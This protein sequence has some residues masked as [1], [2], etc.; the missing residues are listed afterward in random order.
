ML[1]LKD[2]AHLALSIFAQFAAVI[3]HN[4]QSTSIEIYG[5]NHSWIFK[6]QR[7][8]ISGGLFKKQ[9]QHV[10]KLKGWKFS[11]CKNSTICKRQ[12]E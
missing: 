12:E 3:L 6:S 8:V 2:L 11:D 4:E 5:N 7:L 1:M 10:R 9:W